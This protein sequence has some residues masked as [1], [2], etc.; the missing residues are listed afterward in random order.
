MS[1]ERSAFAGRAIEWLPPALRDARRLPELVRKRIGSAVERFA[2]SG[3]GDV[4][5]LEGSAGDYRLRVGDYRILFLR[6]DADA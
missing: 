6:R 4:K 3:I 2:A 5:L 1:G